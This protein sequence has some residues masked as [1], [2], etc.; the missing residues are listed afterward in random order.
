MVNNSLW[1]AWARE[2][3]AIAQS[4]IAY[5]KDPFDIGRFARVTEIA[6]DIVAG[7]TTL[8][9][10]ELVD[11][12]QAQ[13]GYATPKIDVRGAIVQDDKVLLV[14][15]KADGKWCLPGGWGDVAV[16]PAEM[17]A[18]EVWEESGV[19]VRVTRL[20]GVYDTNRVNTPAFYHAYKLVFL[21]E[22]TGGTPAPG[23][24]TLDA[25]FFSLSNLPP[26]SNIRTSTRHLA[27]VFAHHRK[28]ESA[29][30]FD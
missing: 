13:I 9:Q 30:V 26:L 4:G 16:P 22:I 25:G 10:T 7:H 29:A 2:L 15:E 24:E 12:F 19:R 14:Q 18:R 6:A 3:Q 20:V 21:C 8:N 23:D 27:D 28:P 1:L 5:S 11:D 17:V